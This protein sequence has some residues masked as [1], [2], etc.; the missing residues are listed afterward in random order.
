[1]L[2]KVFWSESEEVIGRWGK[3]HDVG[4]QDLHS[5][6]YITQ[7]IRNGSGGFGMWHACGQR[8]HFRELGGEN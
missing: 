5:W 8:E 2:R 7:M 4:L 6:S 3:F 1:M